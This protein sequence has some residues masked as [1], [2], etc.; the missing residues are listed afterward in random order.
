M[1]FYEYVK[2]ELLTSGMAIP[3]TEELMPIIMEHKSF[4]STMNNRWSDDI[5]CYPVMM[6]ALTFS[7]VKPIVLEWIEQNH[8]EAWFKSVFMSEA[9]RKLLFELEEK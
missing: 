5:D 8:P 4:E 6:K 1:T 2:Q 9:D 3:M 7:L